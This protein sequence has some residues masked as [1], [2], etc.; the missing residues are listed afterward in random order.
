MT[1]SME[2]TATRTGVLGANHISRLSQALRISDAWE[3][4]D[5]SQYSLQ[6]FFSMSTGPK[7]VELTTIG[8]VRKEETVG[9]EGS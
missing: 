2:N 5:H 6:S 1:P 8:V 7:E 9:F 3:N 4:P